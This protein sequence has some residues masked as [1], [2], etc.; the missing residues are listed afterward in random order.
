M[1]AGK[2]SIGEQAGCIGTNGEDHGIVT[3]VGYTR[4]GWMCGTREPFTADYQ[5][6]LANDSRVF[7]CFE[8]QLIKLQDPDQ[9]QTR[10]T[11]LELVK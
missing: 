3:V 8:Y 2:F 1:S 9:E 4:S 10:E 6:E 7:G 5:I 11:G